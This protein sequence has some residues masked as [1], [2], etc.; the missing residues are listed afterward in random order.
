M[1]I[2]FLVILKMIAKLLS[3]AGMVFHGFLFGIGIWFAKD[4]YESKIKC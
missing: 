3:W 4:F 2:H 1:D